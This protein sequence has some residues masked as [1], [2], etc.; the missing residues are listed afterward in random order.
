M[1]LHQVHHH[2]L[3]KRE[4]VSSAQVE[5]PCVQGTRI[6]QM[7][8]LA[9]LPVSIFQGVSRRRLSIASRTA[10]L[11]A[12]CYKFKHP[13]LSKPRGNYR[14]FASILLGAVHSLHAYL[15]RSAAF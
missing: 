2:Q 13:Q 8:A 10:S 4:T 15:L 11:M 14:T 7:A 3:A 1:G 6:V 9:P 12:K 5:R